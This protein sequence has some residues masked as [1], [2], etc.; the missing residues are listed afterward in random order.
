[1]KFG[2]EKRYSNASV[3]GLKRLSEIPCMFERLTRIS[4]GKNLESPDEK[5]SDRGN[6]DQSGGRVVMVELICGVFETVCDVT[7]GKW[8]HWV[9][10]GLPRREENDGLKANKMVCG[11]N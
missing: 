8:D 4:V 3:S 1:M 10:S 11:A 7:G 9:N 5:S 2:K 6:W